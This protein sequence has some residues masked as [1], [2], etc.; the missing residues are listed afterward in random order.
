M[1]PQVSRDDVARLH[2]R[3]GRTRP[4]E[5]NRTL[6][7]LRLMFNLARL[8]YFLDPAAENPA[9]GIKK[10]HEE[11]RNR[12]LKLEEL[13]PLAKAI[14]QEPN[15]YVRSALWLYMLSGVRKTELLEAE[16]ADIDWHRG[17]LRL[18]DTK[19]G[20][21]FPPMPVESLQCHTMPN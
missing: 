17:T 14:D 18:P 1:V 5:A 3:I 21:Y 4:Y 7:L 9:E 19:T 8:W 6:D 12:W 13:P 16:W 11:K 2:R 20:G 15:V 10:F